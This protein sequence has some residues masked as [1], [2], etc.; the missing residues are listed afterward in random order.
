LQRRR[1]NEIQHAIMQQHYGQQMQMQMQMGMA[2]LQE[3]AK[4][5]EDRANQA[6]DTN[7]RLAEQFK[8][9]AAQKDQQ[10]GDLNTRFYEAQKNEIAAKK[11]G[12]DAIRSNIEFKVKSDADAKKMGQDFEERM[13]KTG[14]DATAREKQKEREH[15]DAMQRKDQG[16]KAYQT[17]KAERFKVLQTQRASGLIKQDDYDKKVAD[18]IA[19]EYH[20]PPAPTTQPGQPGPTPTAPAGQQQ[21]GG[22]MPSIQDIEA[23]GGSTEGAADN[24]AAQGFN[25]R[26]A[27]WKAAQQKGTP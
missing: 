24:P 13:K 14:L 4:Y 7:R 25:D 9:T 8:T 10:Y 2:R 22:Q 21:G 5:H 16:F 6:E 17:S 11:E 20:E 12:L 3:M 27:Q 15:A 23:Y 18:L 26:V 19:E 1:A